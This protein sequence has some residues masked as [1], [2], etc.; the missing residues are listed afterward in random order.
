MRMH[1]TT[2]ASLQAD[3]YNNLLRRVSLVSGLVTTIAGNAALSG[4]PPNNY[5]HAD[6]VGTASSFMK[7]T[8]IAFYGAG[9]LVVVVR[10][11]MELIRGGG[12]DVRRGR[13]MRDSRDE[14]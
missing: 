2:N 4:G 14:W 7:P 1:S 9:T 13:C 11:V 3:Q 5:G 12:A 6:G 8:G 10:V